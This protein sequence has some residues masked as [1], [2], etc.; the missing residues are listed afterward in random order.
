VCNIVNV[1]RRSFVVLLL[2]GLA[3]PASL[4]SAQP[5]WTAK[6][7][8]TALKLH[9]ITVHGETCRITPTSPGRLTL[10]LYYVGAEAKIACAGGVLRKIDVL[11]ALPGVTSVGPTHPGSTELHAAATGNP[12]LLMT[13]TTVG[14]GTGTRSDSL[15]GN[16]SVTAI[17]NG[18]ITAGRPGSSLSLTCSLADGSPEVGGFQAGDAL[19]NMQCRNGV[20]TSITRAPS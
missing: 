17:G 19:V 2:A 10:R 8:I 4:A 1:K 13:Q 16:F 15:S 9:S 6:G 5:G 18:S 3:A 11:S 20:L 12:T 7:S 14:N